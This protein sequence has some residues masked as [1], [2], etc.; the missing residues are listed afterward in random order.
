MITVD[1][2][3]VHEGMEAEKQIWNQ[4]DWLESINLTSATWWHISQSIREMRCLNSNVL[5]KINDLRYGEKPPS[6]SGLLYL[7]LIF[8]AIMKDFEQSE[9]K[10]LHLIIEIWMLAREL[11]VNLW[12]SFAVD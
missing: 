1:Y 4:K 8:G 12:F 10:E 6:K 9:W 11:Y 5:R 3:N 2:G 7:P